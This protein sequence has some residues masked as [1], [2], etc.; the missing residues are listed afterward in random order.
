MQRVLVDDDKIK[1]YTELSMEIKM[2]EL[3]RDSSRWSQRG[4]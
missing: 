1:H 4:A 3:I 2:F